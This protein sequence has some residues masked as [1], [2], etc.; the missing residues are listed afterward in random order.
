MGWDVARKVAK[1][2]SLLYLVFTKL[3]RAS[4]FSSPCEWELNNV[5]DCGIILP[6]SRCS[7]KL[8]DLFGRAELG[9]DG[10]EKHEVKEELSKSRKQIE[11]SRLRLTKLHNDGF[12]LVTSIRVAGDARENA[13]R[14]EEEEAKR[15]RKEKLEAEAKAGQER[16]E[17]VRSFKD[18]QSLFE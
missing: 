13:R 7:R 15:I 11:E 2:L 4:R 17:E 12:D 16:F 6:Q 8:F 5:A 9:Q 3:D 10:L 14:M 18:P 1:K